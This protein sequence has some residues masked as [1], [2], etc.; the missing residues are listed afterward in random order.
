MKNSIIGALIVI[1]ILIL[2]FLA[3]NLLSNF[4]YWSADN[5]PWLLFAFFIFLAILIIACTVHNLKESYKINPEQTKKYIS[6]QVKVIIISFAIA[7]AIVGVI[8]ASIIFD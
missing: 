4:V 2:C 1:I 5:A 8:V 3:E 7:I 6:Q